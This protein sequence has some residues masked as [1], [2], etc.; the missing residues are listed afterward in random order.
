MAAGTGALATVPQDLG[1]SGVREME[2]GEV[3]TSPLEC[4]GP[5]YRLPL[6]EI[7]IVL[8]RNERGLLDFAEPRE[9]VLDAGC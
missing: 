9:S 4:R 8:A 2:K 5:S 7:P 3:Q 6:E 1:V